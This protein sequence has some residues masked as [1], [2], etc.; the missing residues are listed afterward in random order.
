MVQSTQ[1]RFWRSINNA[2]TYNCNVSHG[3]HTEYQVQNHILLDLFPWLFGKIKNNRANCR[4]T[5]S[6]TGETDFDFLPEYKRN[7]VTLITKTELSQS[8]IVTKNPI[9]H[10]THKNSRRQNTIVEILLQ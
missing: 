2:K 6:S 1:I 5:V 7:P 10:N 4:S 8:I 3:A 9:F